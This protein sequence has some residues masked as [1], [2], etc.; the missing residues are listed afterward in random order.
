MF[1]LRVTRILRRWFVGKVLLLHKLEQFLELL[2]LPGWYPTIQ[3]CRISKVKPDYPM[4][5]N[6][7]KA[8]YASLMFPILD[9]AC[10][11]AKSS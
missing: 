4:F 3:G 1:C 9:S 6:L 2:R 5:F 11:A 8:K 7:C 10:M